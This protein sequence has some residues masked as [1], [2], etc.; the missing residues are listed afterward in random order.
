MAGVSVACHLFGSLLEE[1]E[2]R[3]GPLF[4]QQAQETI[5]P[6]PCVAYS[7]STVAEARDRALNFF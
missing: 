3:Q 2:G 6:A 7:I 4:L 5:P 1:S